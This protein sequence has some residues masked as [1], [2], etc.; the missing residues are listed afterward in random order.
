MQ[1]RLQDKEFLD[2]V[3]MLARE[4]HTDQLLAAVAYN[5][6]VSALDV[7]NTMIGD[8]TCD[9]PVTRDF[10]KD[11]AGTVID[12]LPDSVVEVQSTR[13]YDANTAGNVSLTLKEMAG[14]LIDTCKE[15]R[16][17]SL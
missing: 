3:R 12:N 16:Q 11:Y 2:L 4:Y 9:V 10:L 5:A 6:A 7:A 8:V 14:E 1:H 15:L 13:Y 17:I